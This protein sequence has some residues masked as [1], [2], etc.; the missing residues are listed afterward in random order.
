MIDIQRPFTGSFAVAEGFIGRGMLRGPRFVRLF[1]DVYVSADSP[2]TMRIRSEAARLFVGEEAILSGYSAACFLAAPCVPYYADA[3]VTTLRHVRPQPG[4]LI[5][6]ARLEDDEVVTVDGFVITSPVRTA[7]D[8]IRRLS[9]MDGVAVADCMARVGGFDRDALD[10]VMRR[11][12]GARLTSRVPACVE[13]LDPASESMME[14]RLRVTL[15]VSGLPRPVCQFSVFD[16]DGSFVARLDLAYPWAKLAIEFDGVHHLSR[17]AQTSDLRRHNRLLAL[18]WRVLRFT[19][20]DVYRR[21]EA[22]VA[23]VWNALRMS[24][25][26]A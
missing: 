13:L 26:V 10:A 7:Y 23:A 25:S 9:L 15:V 20:E 22:T 1:P 3:E 21:P 14:S 18:G 16:A 11:H 5:N 17:E 6:R 4:L 12:R 2:Q 8:L 19:A 24:K